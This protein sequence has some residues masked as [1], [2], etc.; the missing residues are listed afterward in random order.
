M[1]DRDS[2]SGNNLKRRKGTR[3]TYSVVFGFQLVPIK[4]LNTL[5]FA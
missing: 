2:K 3:G 1:S 4:I 5:Y